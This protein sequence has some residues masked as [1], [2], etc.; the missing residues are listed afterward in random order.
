MSEE[1]G[2]ELTP[3]DNE[4]TEKIQ[5]DLAEAMGGGDR[6]KYSRF[7][8]AALG[9]IP[10]VGG[11]LA[12][13]SAI[14]AENEQGK[15]NDLTRLWLEEHQSKVQELGETFVEILT[16]LDGLGDDIQERIE[17]PNYLSLVRQ[18]FRE[19]DQSE[20]Q[21]KRDYIRLLLT[22]AGGTALCPDDLVRL[23]LNWI[24]VYHEAHFLVIKGIYQNRG[25]SRG[26]I[27]DRIHGERPREDSAEAD[28][29]KLLIRDLSM[30]SVIR[31]H[32]PTNARGEY[33]KQP[34][35]KRASSSSGTMK[36]AFDNTEPYELTELGEQFVHYTME[37]VV[38][39]LEI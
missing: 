15:V 23:F 34:P 21:E 22:N 12:A 20:T 17:S 24:N 8:L 4:V 33:I 5:R 26:G 39:R 27:W 14:D 28:L 3:T 38:E 31:Q 7:V 30:G 19:W 2:T 36:S 25:I 16:R 9:S 6:K 37:D 18:G 13:S 11:F 1:K 10:W 29:F 32:R 35:K